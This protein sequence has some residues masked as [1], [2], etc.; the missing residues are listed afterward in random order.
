M[1]KPTHDQAH[2]DHEKRMWYLLG[3]G[4]YLLTVG[5]LGYNFADIAHFGFI[6]GRDGI[7]WGRF[8]VDS[9]SG[10][11]VY[12]ITFYFLV[13]LFCRYFVKEAVPKKIK[14]PAMLSLSY[15]LAFLAYVAIALTMFMIFNYF[16][17]D[18]IAYFRNINHDYYSNNATI[19]DYLSPQY[20]NY[21]LGEAYLVV[22]ILKNIVYGLI[23]AIIIHFFLKRFIYKIKISSPLNDLLIRMNQKNTQIDTPSDI[24]DDI[25]RINKIVK[26]LKKSSYSPA[27]HFRLKDTLFKKQALFLCKEV[28]T[29]KPIY[30]PIEKI[31]NRSMPHFSVTGASGYGKGVF[32]QVFLAQTILMGYGA[33]I[34][35]P[36]DDQHMLKNLRY[37]AEMKGVKFHYINFKEY[38]TPQFDLLQNC[39]EYTF[40]LLTNG[41]FPFLEMRQGDSNFYAKDSRKVRE[42]FSSEAKHASCM[43][44]LLKRVVE[45]YPEKELLD[46]A[47]NVPQFITEFEQI[48]ELPICR[49]KES[50]SI[51]D[52]IENGDVI[53]IDCPDLSNEDY[54][55]LLCKSL[56]NRI[57]HIIKSRDESNSKHVFWYVDEFA[58]FVSKP[59][60]SAIEQVRKKGCTFLFNMTS[61]DS[62]IGAKADI[63]TKSFATSVRINSYKLTYCQPDSEVAKSMSGLTGEKIVHKSSMSGQ[64]DETNATVFDDNDRRLMSDKENLI[65]AGIISNLPE[66]VGVLMIT[67][68]SLST[69]VYTGI[70]TYPDS[71]QRPEVKAMKEYP[72]SDVVHIAK[73]DKEIKE[74]D[75]KKENDNV[76][77]VVTMPSFDALTK[78]KKEDSE[79]LQGEDLNSPMLEG[80]SSNSNK[81]AKLPKKMLSYEELQKKFNNK[82]TSEEDES[83]NTETQVVT[84]PSFDALSKNANPTKK[85]KEK[86][87]IKISNNQ[88]KEETSQ[89]IKQSLESALKD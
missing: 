23:A 42:I 52:A 73:E 31:K 65:S 59:V 54:L 63:D 32:S 80:D 8:I 16:V 39:N 77:V 7:V 53:Y 74:K 43:Y 68:T 19:N 29:K 85:P 48:A 10:L 79:N 67:G 21:A 12:I 61:Y 22:Q 58:E 46:D 89:K 20:F 62:L 82:F 87:R 38:T 13:M 30:L 72:M 14:L 34:F 15:A 18:F 60:K 17:M 2:K 84:I 45:K 33:I 83:E 64:V 47:G 75:N 5:Y 35:D 1:K 25:Q 57:L 49:V 78:A 41:M 81:I 27:Q 26:K 4:L 9:S 56:F 6:H 40:N 71:I 37:Y 55:T 3:L 86:P 88:T 36:N 50:F 66:K 51:S 44:D 76:D 24:R 11:S 69:L 28:E 70:L